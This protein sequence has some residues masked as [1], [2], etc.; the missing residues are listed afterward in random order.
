MIHKRDRIILGGVSLLVP[1]LATLGS[2]WALHDSAEY[3]IEQQE[4]YQR[5]QDNLETS[6]DELDGLAADIGAACFGL[7]G[8]YMQDGE[9][10]GTPTSDIVED[11]L[12]SGEPVCGDSRER[13]QSTVADV[14]GRQYAVATAESDLRMSELN[15]QG[16]RSSESAMTGLTAFLVMLSF[17]VPAGAMVMSN[18]SE[19]ES[20]KG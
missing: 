7:V 9:L 3:R 17:G 19:K 1:G 8:P 11:I 15:L 4:A 14:L 10:A 13:I 16:A 2:A 12:D 20:R 18:I 5:A 6:T